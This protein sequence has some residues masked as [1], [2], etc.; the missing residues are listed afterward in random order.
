VS[1]RFAFVSA[2]SRGFSRSV[3]KSLHTIGITLPEEPKTMKWS[4]AQSRG[5]AAEEAPMNTLQKYRPSSEIET[6]DD[7]SGLAQSTD[8]ARPHIVPDLS[9]PEFC[10]QR[11]EECLNLSY[12]IADPKG[13]VAV[14]KLASCW[15]R[16][17]ENCYSQ[18]ATRHKAS[19]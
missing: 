14:L 6:L 12:E 3:C 15:M 7:P 17:A 13:Q 10:R 8:A 11:A 19:A 9:S 18:T 1:K 4:C 2:K 5:A 16:L